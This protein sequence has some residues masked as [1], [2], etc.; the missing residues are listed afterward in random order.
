MPRHINF[1]PLFTAIGSWSTVFWLSVC[2]LISAILYQQ[3]IQNTAVNT[4]S[5]D[6]FVT[7]ARDALQ[8]HAEISL[9][10]KE[11][12]QEVDDGIRRVEEDAKNRWPGVIAFE[13]KHVR[14][15]IDLR[16][17]AAGDFRSA[18]DFAIFC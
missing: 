7:L 17:E 14:S 18:F 8:K 2:I 12:A 4:A 9:K 15:V 16:L 10:I 1:S 6:V 3:S 5:D 11:I 13:S